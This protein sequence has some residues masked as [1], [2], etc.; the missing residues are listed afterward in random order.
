MGLQ[1]HLWVTLPQV[2]FTLFVLGPGLSLPC[3][4]WIRWDWLAST[5]E[6]PFSSSPAL[7]LEVHTT[8]PKLFNFLTGCWAQDLLF[9]RS[10]WRY[11]SLSSGLFILCLWVFSACWQQRVIMS[12]RMSLCAQLSC[13]LSAAVAGICH[14]C[15]LPYSPSVSFLS[16]SPIFLFPFKMF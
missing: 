13:L 15:W 3:G 12:I 6:P 16:Y 8:L 14:H 1:G 10:Q 4:W 9:V 7:G 2:L 11:F 5:R